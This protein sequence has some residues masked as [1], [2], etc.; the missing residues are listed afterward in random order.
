MT[1]VQIPEVCL[2][3]VDASSVGL[4]TGSNGDIITIGAGRRS[5]AMHLDYEQA[6]TISWLINQPDITLEIEFKIKPNP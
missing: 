2:L 4:D 1:L 5:N 6:A 3:E